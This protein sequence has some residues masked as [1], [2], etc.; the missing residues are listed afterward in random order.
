M[1]NILTLDHGRL[2]SIRPDEI[3]TRKPVWWTSSIPVRKSAAG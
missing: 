3:A 1:L 2:V